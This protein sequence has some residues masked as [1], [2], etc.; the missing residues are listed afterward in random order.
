MKQIISLGAGSDT[1]PFRLKS[2]SLQPSMIYHELDFP[3][4]TAQKVA[5]YKRCPQLY[6]FLDSPLTSA[7]DQV[8]ESED[9][10]HGTWYHLHPI[11]L[12][13]LHPLVQPPESF[14]HIETGL[15][16]LIISECCLCYLE[17]KSAD[18]VVNYFLR[19][20]F[21]P[22]TALGLVVYEPIEP[23]D[24][25]GKVMVSNL[26]SRGISLPSLRKYGSTDAQTER[27]GAY[28]FE[29]SAGA[30]MNAMWELD[31][32]EKEKERVAALE[33]MDEVE[34]WR[35]LAGHYCVFWGCKEGEKED[36]E[37]EEKQAW[38]LWRDSV[39]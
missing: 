33:M 26:A 16:T 15:P 35:L 5:L 19:R 7:R 30:D 24:A 37:E 34:E 4:N 1:R 8:F 27:M 6:E 32:Q 12:R 28:G 23:N 22:T 20:H 18:D 10:F 11:D 17:P 29:D 39:Q 9:S 2:R 3:S 31:T 14:K 25:F 36:K 38:K 21:P 13:T